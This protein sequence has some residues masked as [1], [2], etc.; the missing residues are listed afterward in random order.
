MICD[1]I[2]EWDVYDAHRQLTG[3]KMMR[4]SPIATGDFHLVVH[5]CLFSLDGRMLL[6]KRAPTKSGWTNYW[7]ISCGGSAVSGEDSQ[8]AMAREA[9]EEIGFIHDFAP[10][11]P[12][13]TVVTPVQFDDHYFLSADVDPMS[14]VLQRLEVSR[15]QWFTFSQ[16]EDLIRSDECIPYPYWSTIFEKYNEW[17]LRNS[18]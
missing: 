5:L 12:V 7:D 15:V 13:F 11:R 3:R 1:E 6:Q 9:V 10:E 16:I 2:E 17:F 14:M 8:Q 18:R 4:G